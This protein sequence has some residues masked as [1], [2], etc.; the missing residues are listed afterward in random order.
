[1]NE[2]MLR[3][4]HRF[5]RDRTRGKST[6]LDIYVGSGLAGG[7]LWDLAM[8]TGLIGLAAGPLRLVT[9]DTSAYFSTVRRQA[10]TGSPTLTLCC[11]YPDPSQR[12]LLTESGG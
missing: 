2:A 10:R 9:Y 5:P 3:L 6:G 1:M 11:S 4:V 7:S 12:P 8:Y